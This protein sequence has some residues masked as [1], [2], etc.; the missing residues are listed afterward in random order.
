MKR[1]ILLSVF[2]FDPVTG[3]EPYVGWNFAMMLADDY[4]VHILTREYCCNLIAGH[5]EVDKLTFH[6]VDFFGCQRH[7]HL[8]RYIKP[9][10][11][12]WQTLVLFKVIALQSRHAFEVVH[13]VTYN[14]VDVP[15]FLWLT[16][17]ARFIWGPVGAGQTS[18]PSLAAVYGDHWWKDRVRGL[19]KAL[20]RYNPVLRAAIRRAAIVLIA[21]QETADRLAGLRFRSAMMREMATSVAP[22]WEPPVGERGDRKV[23]LLWLSH[24]LPRKGL[25]LALDGF[26]RALDRDAGST[27]MELVVIGAGVDLPRAKDHAR[28]I[29]LSERVAFLGAVPH[30]EVDR[31]FAENDIFLFTSVQDTTGTVLLEAMRNAQ[32]IIALNHQGAKAMITQGGGRLV[33]IGTYDETADRLG[34]AIVELA[35][36][37]SLRR[38]MGRLALQ[39]VRARHTWAAKRTQLLDIYGEVLR[40]R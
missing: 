35:H 16:P 12:L 13:H 17:K 1:K 18:P 25:T 27:D 20:T 3:S 2:A 34:A 4:D 29:G 33:D 24:V 19:V 22:E 28:R 26:R 38:Q 11:V 37:P 6:F 23:R 32:P 21:N 7:N 14:T 39:E 5:P 30:S 15:G 8:W 9:Y 10:Y 40:D 36:D 31:R